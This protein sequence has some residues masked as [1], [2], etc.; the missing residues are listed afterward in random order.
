MI[1]EELCGSGKG[2]FVGLA[3]VINRQDRGKDELLALVDSRNAGVHAVQLMNS[4][5]IV[6]EWHLLAAAQ[7]AV[8]ALKGDYM[9][10]RSLDVEA[11]V[12]ASGQKQISKAL[13]QVGVRDHT[14][15]IAVVVIG[16]DQDA[17][18]TQLLSIIEDIGGEPDPPFAPDSAKLQQITHVF[19][20]S[21]SEVE[22]LAE[23][24][25]PKDIQSAVSRCVVSRVSSVAL[26]A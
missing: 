22:V 4:S 9:I 15:D 5:F 13:S 11:A 23:S 20:I 19:G 3:E 6:D 25:N 1:I 16:E 12:Y 26:D 17:V 10:S 18:R 8:N 2:F 24:D 7:N 21:D 14:A